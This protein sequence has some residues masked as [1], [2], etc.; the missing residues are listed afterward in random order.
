MYVFCYFIVFFF[1]L[2]FVIL[3]ALISVQA[4]IIV[5]EN[6]NTNENVVDLIDENINEVQPILVSEEDSSEEILTEE[7]QERR[8]GIPLQPCEEYSEI[9]IPLHIRYLLLNIK[10]RKN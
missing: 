5:D 7:E 1:T 9:V 2:A 3:F 4:R 10:I 8:F 6:D